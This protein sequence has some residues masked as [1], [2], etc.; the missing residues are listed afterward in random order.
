VNLLSTTGTDAVHEQAAPVQ[1]P[2]EES[3]ELPG[4]D[5]G[6]QPISVM[7]G[8]GGGGGADAESGSESGDQP[9]VSS[10]ERQAAAIIIDTAQS[11]QQINATAAAHR[12]QI[13]S[14]FG[15]VRSHIAGLLASSAAGI[16]TFLT[17]RQAEVQAT[18]ASVLTAGQAMLTGTMRAAQGQ[19]QQAR[20]VLDGVAETATAA[21]EG[22][23][24]QT[25]GRITGLVDALPLPDL[26]GVSA[27]R[28][29]ARALAGRAASAVTGALGQVRGLIGAALQ[30]GAGLL[31]S[32]LSSFNEAASSALNRIG[33]TV[34]AAVQSVFAGLSRIGTTVVEGLRRALDGTVLAG[35]RRV[36][37]TLSNNLATA[38][39]QAI[40]ALHT[41]RDEHL[42]AVREGRSA[43]DGGQNLVEEA[44]QNNAVVVKT[45]R[46]RGSSLLGSV[47]DA[48][49][50][51]AS[52]LGQHLGALVGRV[53]AIV[54]APLAPILAGLHQVGQA[55]SGF[56]Q[57]LLPELMAGIASVAGFVRSL[58]QNPLDA[59]VNFAAGAV[60]RAGQFFAGLP[61]RLLGGNLSLPS[62]AELI[63]D[64]RASGPIVKPPPGPIVKPILT[65]LSL[66][67]LTVGAI[68]L[69]FAPSLVAA[70]A[71]VLAA[72]GI[73]VAPVTLLIIVGVVAVAA[74]IAALVLLYL[75]YRLV[76][77]GPKPPPPVIT[78]QTDFSAPDGSPKNRDA[79]GV[80][81]HVLFTGSAAGTWTASAGS[82]RR[83]TGPTFTW[84]APTRRRSVTIRLVVGR[85][86]ASAKLS[87][88][89]PNT[90][91][92]HKL[93]DL[94]PAP[95]KF[96]AGMELEFEYHPLRVSFGKA[97]AR[98]VEGPASS[99]KGYYKRFKRKD[100]HHNPGP[101][102][103]FP[104][105][106]NNRD[107]GGVKDQASWLD[108]PPPF[109]DGSFH[110]KIPNKFR[111]V[112]ES[113]DGKEFTTVIQEFGMEASGK[114][115][116][117]KA[118]EHTEHP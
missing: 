71:A 89:E 3:L 105:A 5:S 10:P 29:G 9:G 69:Y 14:R 66:L 104:I 92:G 6:T 11:E 110:W 101:V 37:S 100:L 99:I 33:S 79:V 27:I 49:G 103:F 112:T 68:V 116:V 84:V 55:I 53:I 25:A 85:A 52:A 83:G 32:L 41:N 64:P 54:Q 13:S 40:T 90:I 20:T 2:P 74:L 42:Q 38:R 59:A 58:V 102:K 61:A 108:Q 21:L 93:R 81:E 82:P 23:V 76:K 88:L 70:V 50:A 1:E 43:A 26:P 111:V 57:S 18:A 77:P 118:G 19:I 36:E 8:D 98:E 73:T 45:F 97:A 117:D 56:I 48:I 22:Q 60:S 115:S 94:T 109:S 106:E 35:L 30:R 7:V 63:G 51:G 47:L 24:S 34:Q 72:L 107:A 86:A 67:F 31:N 28:A 65:I 46:E 95:G 12:G 91:V 78:H 80:G 62:V 96:G 16:R 17:A 39:R 75:L 44:R 113:G 114:A 4:S 15:A 87:V